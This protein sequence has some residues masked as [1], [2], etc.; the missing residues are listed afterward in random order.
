LASQS[1]DAEIRLFNPELFAKRHQEL[2]PSLPNLCPSAIDKA[3]A[4]ISVSGVFRTGPISGK[5]VAIPASRKAK[6]WQAVMVAGTNEAIRRRVFTIRP[7]D[8]RWV[9]NRDTRG[10]GFEFE[11]EGN[12]AYFHVSDAGWDELAIKVTVWPTRDIGKWGHVAMHHR[13]AAYHAGD[14]HASGWLERRDGAWLQTS[15]GPKLYCRIARMEL[16]SQFTLQTPL[17][18]AAVGPLRM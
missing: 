8:N 10:I 18:F 11:V 16:A 6:I 12:P 5:G 4:G 17:G 2:R 1:D 7:G 13:D 3:V 9:T 14:L 15:S